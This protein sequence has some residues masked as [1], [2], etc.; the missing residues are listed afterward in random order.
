MDGALEYFSITVLT[1]LLKVGALAPAY[2][3]LAIPLPLFIMRVLHSTF[4]VSAFSH[5][6]LFE[7]KGQ[8]KAKYF[9]IDFY[10]L[11]SGDFKISN[12]ISI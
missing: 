6:L 11:Q 1:T 8:I 5:H 3:P 12:K 7:L 10:H 9:F 2:P 4:F